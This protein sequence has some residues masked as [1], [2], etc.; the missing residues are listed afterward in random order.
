MHY[1][2]IYLNQIKGDWMYSLCKPEIYKI[3]N[4]NQLLNNVESK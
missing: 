1:L 4:E 2:N 3:C